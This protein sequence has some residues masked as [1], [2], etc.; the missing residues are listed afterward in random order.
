MA[1]APRPEARPIAPHLSVWR[2]HVTMASSILH[3]ATG[4]ALYGAAVVFVV[5]LLAAAAGPEAYAPIDALL[6]SAFGQVCIYLVV[7]ALAYHFANGLRH[8]WLDTGAGFE[9]KSANATAWF[10]ILFGIAAP[11]VLWAVLNLGA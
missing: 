8:L 4:A 1:G 9:L 2:W 10:S 5:W 6:N 7:A 11:I 3:R